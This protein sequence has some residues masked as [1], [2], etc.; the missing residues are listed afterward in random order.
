MSTKEV[1][2]MQACIG[3]SNRTTTKRAAAKRVGMTERHFYRCYDKWV[4]GGE[5]ALTHKAR[6]AQGNHRY[7]TDMRARICIVPV[8]E[9]CSMYHKHALGMVVVGA[10]P[11]RPV[12]GCC[13][14]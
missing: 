11:V 1:N 7:S 6:G 10:P 5:H 14:Y 13:H 4:D 2:I 3:V 12:Q 8:S 9:A